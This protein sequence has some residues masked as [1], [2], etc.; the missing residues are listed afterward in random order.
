MAKRTVGDEQTA[1]K[2]NAIEL[3]K[4]FHERMKKNDK[5]NYKTILYQIET[6]LIGMLVYRL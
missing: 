5:M 4:Q 6:K 2:T 3:I 1:D